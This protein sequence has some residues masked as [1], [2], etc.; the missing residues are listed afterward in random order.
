MFSQNYMPYIQGVGNL[1]LNGC[2]LEEKCRFVAIAVA[3]AVSQ[4]IPVPPGPVPVEA[5]PAVYNEQCAMQ[6]TSCINGY[7]EAAVLDVPY[8]QEMV[9][10]LWLFRTNAASR[11]VPSNVLDGQDFLKAWFG[12]YTLFSDADME[13]MN[14]YARELFVLASCCC[15]IEA[16]KSKAQ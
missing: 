5:L 6:V 12:A 4:H 2:G 3:L 10:K 13:L 14:R 11:S 1:H 8:A 7:N 9:R 16:N 15:G